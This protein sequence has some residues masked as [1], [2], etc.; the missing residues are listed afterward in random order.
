M[1]VTE[2]FI[3]LSVE[4]LKCDVLKLCA[5]CKLCGVNVWKT[6]LMMNC[7]MRKFEF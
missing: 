3:C 6:W 7:R 2:S 1:V 4:V 5:E